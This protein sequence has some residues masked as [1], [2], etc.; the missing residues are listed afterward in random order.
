MIYTGLSRVSLSLHYA[1][2]HGKGAKTT[3]V[4]EL[5]ALQV[6]PE[7][8]T[9]TCRVRKC[10]AQRDTKR[11]M[12]MSGRPGGALNQGFSWDLPLHRGH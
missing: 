11:I 1:Y 9:P 2:S 7:R 10:T 5:L 3:G 6:R 8:K 4:Q 12:L